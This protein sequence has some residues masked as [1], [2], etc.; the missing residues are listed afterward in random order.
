[1]KKYLK[2]NYKQIIIKFLIVVAVLVV[3]LITK[4][5]FANVFN[6]RYQNNNFENI[7]FIKGIISFTYTENVGAAFSMFSGQVVFL[8]I[9]SILFIAIFVAVDIWFKEKS[10]WFASGI[11]LVIGGAIGNL[12]DRI[13]LGYVRDFISFDII[14]NFAICN[15][16]DCCITIGCVLIGVY[17]VLTLINEKKDKNKLVESSDTTGMQNTIKDVNLEEKDK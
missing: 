6:D 7:D 15:F 8:I 1:M 4:I 13:F 2:E 17:F 16:A 9:F 5:V 10:W 11:S 14:K 12:V 3:D